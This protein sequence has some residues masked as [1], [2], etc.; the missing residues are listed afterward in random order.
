MEEELEG[1]RGYQFSHKPFPD[2][3][4]FHPRRQNHYHGLRPL[5][6][7]KE[8]PETRMLLL[9]LLKLKIWEKEVRKAKKYESKPLA[10]E[11]KKA[12]EVKHVDP[13]PAGGKFQRKF[14]K[15]T[16]LKLQS[17]EVLQVAIDHPEIKPK[18]DKFCHFHN[19]YRHNTNDCFH[20]RDEIKRLVQAGHLKEFIYHD[21]QSPRGQKRKDP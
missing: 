11:K 9:E 5:Q 19:D 3:M 18:S 17:T 12:H 8:E 15:Y 21:K 10:S 20:L 2:M 6:P 4:T 14:E 7:H 13:G 1:E 16:P